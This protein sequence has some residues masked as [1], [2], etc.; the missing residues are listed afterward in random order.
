M[1]HKILIVDDEEANLRL[2]ERLFRSDY[3]VVTATSGSDA[4]EL[5]KMHDFALIISDQRMPGMTGIEFLKQAAQ[6]RQHTVRIILTGY[7]DVTALVEVINSGVV[8]KYVAKPWTNEDLQQ[9][10]VRAIE[11]YE[12]IKQQYELTIQNNRL[13]ENVN[14]MQRLCVR[15]IGETLDLKDSFLHQ[16]SQRVSGYAAAIGYRLNLDSAELEQLSLAAFLHDVGK[17]GI[18]NNLLDKTSPLTREEYQTG[19]LSAERGVGML[20]SIPEMSDIAATVRHH[21]ENFDGTG[22]PENLAGEQ[23]PLFSRIIAVANAYDEM[24]KPNS[25]DNASTHEEAIKDLRSGIGKQFDSVVVEEFCNIEAIDKIRRTIADGIS[26]MRLPTALVACDEA[27][28]STGE[29]LQKFK[30]EP[31]LALDILRMGNPA[32][33]GQPTAQLLPLMSKIGEAKL[34]A[35]LGQYGL[36]APDE[37]TKARTIHALRQA[38]AAQLLAAHTCLIHPDDAYTLG[39][40]YNV[41]ENLLFNLFPNEMLELS[42]LDINIRSHRQIEMFGIDAAQISRWMLE[43]CGVPPALTMAIENQQ[44]F[45]H[46]THP[47][48]LLMQTAYKIA[49]N[50]SSDNTPTMNRIENSALETLNLSRADLNKI[51]DRANFISEES[52]ELPEKSS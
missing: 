5:L 41:G 3:K 16:H 29:I 22:F 49:Y 42:I 25:A 34:R 32:Q 2:L 33:N 14:R 11:H 27:R 15:L 20:A 7:T 6:M 48:A 31:L 40:L 28:M 4:L 30:T 10:V 37:F 13:I 43:A 39:L 35:L 52:I 38:F 17:I 46:I 9:T 24:T 45:M 26:G 51:Y 1:N 19:K 8:Y 12:T 21:T 47:T 50:K 23:I 36:P 18:P 44:D